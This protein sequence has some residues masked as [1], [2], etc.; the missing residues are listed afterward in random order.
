[1]APAPGR[2]CATLGRAVDSPRLFR[3]TSATC[4]LILLIGSAVVAV[5][6]ARL[7]TRQ[8]M[9]WRLVW[10]LWTA[11]QATVL[12]VAVLIGTPLGVSLGV[13]YQS[14]HLGKSADSPVA[15]ARAVLK[16]GF[17]WFFWFAITASLGAVANAHFG[18]PGN[19]LRGVIRSARQECEARHGHATVAVPLLG[20]HWVCSPEHPSMLVG[21]LV[22]GS[23]RAKY[24]TRNLLLS[25][26]LVSVGLSKLEISVSAPRGMPPMRLSAERASLR[27]AWPWARQTRASGIGRA[28]FVSAVAMV[29]AA[30]AFGMSLRR[31][32]SRVTAIGVATAG[33]VAAWYTLRTLDLHQRAGGVFWG[34][35]PGTAVL[36]MIVV[37][38][39][40]Q[41]E[42]IT[43]TGH[44]VALGWASWRA[45]LRRW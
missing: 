39:L 29:V 11:A 2:N 30:L 27:G 17:F 9:P 5:G 21:E 14:K 23:V 32:A 40:L 16:A 31:R 25:E 38:W 22:R 26:D 4:G 18:A 13:L 34:V 1:M 41:S 36:T 20:A 33:A 8:T 35:V 28:I 3:Y 45:A 44:K 7:G 24:S 37:W 19:T 42:R 6:L 15:A 43:W 12:E 10:P